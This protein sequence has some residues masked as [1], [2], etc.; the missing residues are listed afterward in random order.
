M[1]RRA[2]Y[3]GHVTPPGAPG[4]A[5]QNALLLARIERAKQW[6]RDDVLRWRNASDEERSRALVDLLDLMDAVRQGRGEPWPL[7]PL[8]CHRLGYADDER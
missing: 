8:E 6:D 4:E 7:E 5:E 3:T 1:S 2:S